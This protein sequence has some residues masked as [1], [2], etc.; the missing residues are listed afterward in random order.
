[1]GFVALLFGKAPKNTQ[2]APA[3]R[4]QSATR[5]QTRRQLVTM[6]LR[7]TL[8]RT[9]LATDCI[10]AEGLVGSAARERGLHVQLVIRSYQPTLLSYVVAFEHALRVT[11]RRLDPLSPT[12]MLGITWRFEPENPLTWPQLP[13]AQRRPAE[14]APSATPS[15]ASN[16]HLNALLQP[17]DAT[18]RHRRAAQSGFSPT[19]PM[20][21]Q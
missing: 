1:M 11:L 12:W 19:L 20:Q 9:G 15:S 4:L 8:K 21:A 18:F 6:A 17:G 14:M 16:A 7:D 5:E 2:Q 10:T 3:S 13:S